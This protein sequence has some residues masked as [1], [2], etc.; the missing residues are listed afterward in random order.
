MSDHRNHQESSR[1]F[2]LTLAGSDLV[3][4]TETNSI[5]SVVAVELPQ[6]EKDSR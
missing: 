1:V 2:V 3:Y 5:Y 6:S 4:S